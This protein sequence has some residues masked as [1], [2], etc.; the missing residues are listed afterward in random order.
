MYKNILF[1]SDFIP[2][3][4]KRHLLFESVIKYKV[5]SLADFSCKVKLVLKRQ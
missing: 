3:V 5:V 1:R 4:V 2:V